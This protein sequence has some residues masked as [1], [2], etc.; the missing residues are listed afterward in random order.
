MDLD[1]LATLED[2]H[3][4]PVGAHL[5]AGADQ[6]ARHRVERLGDFDVM[7]PMHL[8]RGVDRQVVAPGRCRQQPGLLLDG[9]TPR[10]GGTG[11]CHGSA[12]PARSRHHCLGPSLGVG[13]IDERLAGEERVAHE[14]HRPL[15]PWLVLRAAHPGRIDPE[16]ARLGVLDERLVQPWRQRVGVVDDGRQ[17]VGDHRGE[18]AAEERPRRFEPVDHRLGGLTEAS[19]TRS[20]AASS[21]P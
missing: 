3:Q 1:Q 15:H 13:E 12:C 4:R 20:S 6:V 2:A 10:P 21:R 11:W 18:H 16:P 7:I 19:T 14:R 8:R 9:R 17:V 5:D